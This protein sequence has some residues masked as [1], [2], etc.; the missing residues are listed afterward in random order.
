M[1]GEKGAKIAA[2]LRGCVTPLEMFREFCLV[3]Q[4]QWTFGALHPVSFH[5]FTVLGV[6]MRDEIT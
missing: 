3:W 6:G 4:V 5:F 2:D 1:S